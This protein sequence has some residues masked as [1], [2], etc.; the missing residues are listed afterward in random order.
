MLTPTIKPNRASTYHR[1]G[2]VSM[3]DAIRQ[4]WTRTA[5]PSDALLTTLP[6]SERRR[7]LR[8]TANVATGLEYSA[9]DN[10]GYVLA[11]GVD[12]EEWSRHLSLR[13]AEAEA[14]SV[15]GAW[16]IWHASVYDGDGKPG[17]VKA[18]W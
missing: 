11:T 1:D 6:E 8:H 9:D 16:S 14:E 12:A 13:D 5:S 2:T 15:S 7:V 4:S 10:A 18:R 17:P 3:W